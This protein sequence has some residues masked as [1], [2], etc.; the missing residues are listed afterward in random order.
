MTVKGTRH[1][2]LCLRCGERF[3]WVVAFSQHLGECD[4][5]VDLEL[6]LSELR[7]AI[8]ATDECWLMDDPRG[9]T[10]VPKFGIAPGKVMKAH[11]ILASEV[12]GP[13]QKSAPILCHWC[14]NRKCMNPGH[15]YWGTSQT[16]SL[17]AWRNGKRT[18]S[19]EQLE[20]MRL[21][22]RRSEKHRKRMLDHNRQ[23]AE[24]NSGDR[25]WTRRSQQSMDSWKDA[26]QAGKDRAASAAK[27][28]GDAL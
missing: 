5:P 12:H 14:D 10:L 18:M 17:D 20:A 4:L 8:G 23:L 28:G 11:E 26:I 16:N 22:L 15:L 13:R 9:A 3:T 27:E 19:A 25:H 1:R 2:R 6:L 21:G 7:V 24:R